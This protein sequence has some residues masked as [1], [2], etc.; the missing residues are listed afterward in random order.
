MNLTLK[1]IATEAKVSIKTVS[2]VINEEPMVSEKT[3]RKVKTIIEELGYQPNLIARSLKNRKTNTIGF[4]IPD[5]GNP[6][7]TE[8]VKGCMDKLYE[9]GYFVF[10]GSYEDD[11]EKEIEFIKDLN[12]RLIDGIIIIPSTTEDRDISIFEKI[13]CPVVF[14]DREISGIK[15]DI[16]ISGNKKGAY[17]AIRQL[18]ER[19]NRKIVILNG[20]R[21]LKTSMKRYEGWKKAMDENKLFDS[22]L[23]FWGT[24][25]IESGYRSM[26]EAFERLDKIDAVFAGNDIV[27]LG[28]M[29]AIKEKGYRIPRDIRII[30]FDDMFFS[31]YLNPPLS[32]VA[33]QLYEEGK[34]AAA[35]LLEKIKDPGISTTK[36]IVLACEVIMRDTVIGN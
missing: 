20:N 10:L 25:T 24:F 6:A 14:L 5:I 26:N 33:V 19:G 18:I 17:S 36:R 23:V 15:K 8:M 13:R 28:A 35:L 27:A 16:V 12:S 32:S 22:D 2:R 29:N 7:F 11:N 34:T 4:I 30:G 31:K 21:T 1:D 9:N 3:R